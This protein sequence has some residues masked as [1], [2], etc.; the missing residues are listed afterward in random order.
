MLVD[1]IVSSHEA[2]VKENQELCAMVMTSLHYVSGEKHEKTCLEAELVMVE[3]WVVS[4]QE[5]LSQFQESQ[6]LLQAKI[7][8]LRSL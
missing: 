2:I 5:S 6:S 4:A 8:E 1:L 3:R 7:E